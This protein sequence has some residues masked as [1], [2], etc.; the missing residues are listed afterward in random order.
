MALSEEQKDAIR[1]RVLERGSRM[2]DDLAPF[3]LGKGCGLQPGFPECRGTHCMF[4]AAEV[5][6]DQATGKHKIT[7]A[8]C[9]FQQAA[10]QAGPIAAGLEALAFQVAQAAGAAPKIIEPPTGLIR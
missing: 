8:G 3:Y 4:F 10:A 9:C 1:A 2:H 6:L 7:G 5:D